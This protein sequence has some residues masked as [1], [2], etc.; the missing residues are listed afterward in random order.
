[1]TGEAPLHPDWD[2]TRAQS[3]VG[4]HVLVGIRRY[5]AD[6]ATLIEQSQYHGII[7]DAHSSRGFRIKCLGDRSGETETLPPDTR[8][9]LDAQPGE[10]RLHSTGE[11]VVDPDV[12]TSWSFTAPKN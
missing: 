3:L 5:E 7:V 10:Y 6:G 12:T 4:K 2:E 1:M 8:A 9:F 11:I